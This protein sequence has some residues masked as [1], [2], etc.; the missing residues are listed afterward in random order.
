MK[1][2]YFLLVFLLLVPVSADCSAEQSVEV[3]WMTSD[4]GL[5][6]AKSIAREYMDRNPH[7]IKD[8]EYNVSVRV[9]ARA[10]NSDPASYPQLDL[11]QSQ[12]VDI[13]EIHLTG[14][15]ALA[16]HLVNLN[17]YNFHN[18]ITDRY[19]FIAQNNS[20][21]DQLIAVPYFNDASL[22]FYRPDLREKYVNDPVRGGAV[23]SEW[24]IIEQFAANW[25][26]AQLA[27]NQ[28][29]EN[30]EVAANLLEFIIEYEPSSNQVT[31]F[32]NQIPTSRDMLQD[33]WNVNLWFEYHNHYYRCPNGLLGATLVCGGSDVGGGDLPGLGGVRPTGTHLQRVYEQRNQNI[34][35]TCN[36][37]C[38]TSV[39]V[40]EFHE[41]VALRQTGSGNPVT[42]CSGIMLT[43]NAVLTAAHC[44]SKGRGLLGESEAYNADTVAF[45]RNVNDTSVQNFSITDVV[46]PQ[47]PNNENGILFDAAIVFIEESVELKY[48]GRD[49]LFDSSATSNNL[50]T[51]KEF[52]KYEE[53]QGF[54]GV[55]VGF[56]MYTGTIRG[57][58]RFADVWALPC[59]TDYPL[60]I[61]ETGCAEEITFV[62]T[63][64]KNTSRDSCDGDSGGPLFLRPANDDNPI[65]L[66]AITHAGIASGMCGQGGIYTR[67][68]TVQAIEWINTT[69][70]NKAPTASATSVTWGKTQ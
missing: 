66:I 56:G 6:F 37:N 38:I 22:L 58:K 42:V 34:D 63:P 41:V 36:D 29:G 50:D 3:T 16:D 13:F 5:K 14:P 4:E 8:V 2:L 40:P 31:D 57:V 60:L 55:V 1:R 25:S 9:I 23:D 28:S 12:E 49:L 62:A 69:L 17:D 51:Y 48:Y 45:G 32:I 46:Y 11:S 26:G 24:A 52:F 15:R 30:I 21:N 54:E 35:Q 7:T 43:K 70:D 59:S 64:P 19:P 68:D 27:I 44:F 47:N 18:T 39:K 65:V 33:D 20:L 67:V 53:N 61:G 10:A